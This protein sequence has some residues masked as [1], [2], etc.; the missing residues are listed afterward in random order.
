MCQVPP[1]RLVRIIPMAC[2]YDQRWHQSQCCPE[3]DVPESPEPGLE[4]THG[5]PPPLSFVGIERNLEEACHESVTGLIAT[6]NFRGGFQLPGS[7]K[8]DLLGASASPT[9]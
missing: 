6:K 7:S 2:E 3:P 5:M 1:P 8:P 4:G 9:P